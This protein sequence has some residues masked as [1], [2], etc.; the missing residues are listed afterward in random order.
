MLRL[1]P[2]QLIQLFQRPGGVDFTVFCNDLLRTMCADFGIPESEVSTCSRTDAKDGGVDTRINRGSDN[3]QTGFLGFRTVWQF[4]AGNEANISASKIAAEIEKPFAKECVKSGYAYRACI[5]DTITDD[6]MHSLQEAAEKAVNA[7]N[8]ACPSPKIL[9][10]DNISALANR[11]PAL[12]MRYKPPLSSLAILFEA[13]RSNVTSVTRVFVPGSGFE[14]MK[15]LV[16]AHADFQRPV[17]DAVLPLRGLPGVG[18]TRTTYE[19]LA[20]LQGAAG[21]VLYTDSEESALDL[22]RM[23]ANDQ[24]ARAIM[25]VDECSLST[26]LQ[27][28]NTLRGCRHRVRCISIYNGAVTVASEK[29][30]LTIN[31]LTSQELDQILRANFPSVPFDRLRAYAQLAEG[32]VRLAADM[33]QIDPQIKTAG[34]VSPVL[35]NIESYYRLR[36]TSDQQRAVEAIALLKRVR[37]KGEDETELDVLCKITNWDR[38][39]L[40]EKLAAIKDAPGFVERGALYYRV[41]PEIIAIVAFASGWRRWVD[42][43][44]DAFLS[45]VTDQILEALLQRVSESASPE[46]RTIVRNFFRKFADAFSPEQLVSLGMVNRFI[47]LIETDPIAYLPTLRR[48]VEAATAEQLTSSPEST[49]GSWGP[50]RQLVW[51]AERFAQFKEFFTDAEAILFKLA[52]R[53]SEPAIGNNATKTWQNLFR[54]QLSGTPLSL[55]DRLSILQSRLAAADESAGEVLLGALNSIFDFQGFRTLGPPVVAG[56]IPPGDW[57]PANAEEFQTSLRQ[58]LELLKEAAR[59]PFTVIAR[60]AEDALVQSVD[61]LIRH[62][63]LNAV[64][65]TVSI[66][67][68]GDESR[69]KLAGRLENYVAWFS[70]E[71]PLDF[72]KEYVEKVALWAKELKPKSL[73]GRL[74][75]VVGERSWQYYGREKEFQ[76]LLTSLAIELLSSEA[77]FAAEFDWLISPSAKAAFEFGYALG[78][79]DVKAENLDKLLNENSARGVG[80]VRGYVAGLLHGAKFDPLTINTGLDALEDQNPIF[81]FQVGL[82][83]GNPVRVF[84]RA[85]RMIEAGKIPPYQLTNFTHWVGDRHVNTNEVLTSLRLLLTRARSGDKN[86]SDA[87]MDFLGARY[88]G[89]NLL[90]I[91][92]AD[93]ALVWDGLTTFVDHPGRESFWWA[94]VLSAVAPTQPMVAVE[95]AARAIVS[96]EFALRDEASKLLSEFAGTY[97]TEVMEAVGRLMLTDSTGW[98]FYVGKYSIFFTLPTEVV[99]RWLEQHGVEGARKIARH[100]PEPS[101]LPDG[102]QCVPPLTEYVLRTFEND[103]RTFAE[104]CA[105]VHSFQLYVG[106]FAAAKEGEASIAQRFSNHPLRRIREWSKVEEQNTKRMA[107][108]HREEMDEFNC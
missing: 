1:D 63:L 10:V 44:T 43:R 62:R 25:V 11:Y 28:T 71:P 23:L 24:G 66:S 18:K 78:T 19:C 36:L 101:I 9:S 21:L 50:R 33:C 20:N 70:R 69:A 8:P 60:G 30:E 27:L 7:I 104:F 35:Q 93:L 12:A 56:R 37:H 64:R 91:L 17:P 59:S 26:Q 15:S 99:I 61:Q 105:G 75:E 38:H 90:D 73:H 52:L 106:D 34:T 55:I 51:A 40:E 79:C 87:M 42:G 16:L 68:L 58:G 4:K 14:G 102:S 92:E 45:G 103:D 107:Q 85:I 77:N 32:F 95:L 46:V 53:E 22:A 57:Y 2:L 89:G 81:A 96:D 98:H 13:W 41:T 80:L 108:F 54:M 5:C 49:R 88:G 31:M 86:C 3:D 74:V 47:N 72:P 39:D 65:E 6:K 48:V 97:P 29:G 67:D 83:A 82:A 76:A 94:K 84:D 100:L